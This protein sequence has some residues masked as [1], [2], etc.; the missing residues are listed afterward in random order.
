[1][2]NDPVLINDWHVIAPASELPEGS[3]LAARLLGED[4]VL[5]RLNGQ[6]LAWQDL[7]LHR[8]TRLSLGKIERERVVCPYH[9]WTYDGT[10]Q[11]VHI[12]AHPEQTPPAKAQVKRYQAQEKYGLIW[13]SLG[14]PA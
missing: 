2:I 11:C 13:V 8:G 1:M 4:I 12:P 10:G 6:V 5:W 14:Q 9:G 3:L 7:C